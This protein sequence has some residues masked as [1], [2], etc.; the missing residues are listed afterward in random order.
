MALALALYGLHPSL[1]ESVHIRCLDRCAHHFHTGLFEDAAEF[2]AE[3]RVV[4]EDQV[5]LAAQEAVNVI[6]QLARDPCHELAARVRRDANDLDHAR[7]VMDH[8]QHIVRD[9]PALGSHVDSEEVVGCDDV[10]V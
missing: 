2:G 7:G 5:L 10:C 4:G 1:R 3:P 8:E 9:E 6:R